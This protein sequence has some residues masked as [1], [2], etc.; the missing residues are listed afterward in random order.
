MRGYI[1]LLALVTIGVSLLWFGYSLLIGQ[2]SGVRRQSKNGRRRNLKRLPTP[3]TAPG[4]PAACPMCSTL[5][6]KGDLVR[7]LAFPSVSGGKDRLMHIRGCIYCLES[8]LHLQRNCP[9]CGSALNDDSILVAR[10]FERPRRH[11]HVHVLG[12]SRCRKLGIM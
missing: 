2:L 1:Q 10:L 8:D 6:E 9:I 11:P 3:K 5:L 12:C 4:D 7:T